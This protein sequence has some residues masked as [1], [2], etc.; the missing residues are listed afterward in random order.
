TL[1]P[2][3]SLV[4]SASE[5]AKTWQNLTG[6]TRS[7]AVVGGM[8]PEVKDYVLLAACR[9]SEYAYEYAFNGKERNGA[10]TYWLLDSLQ[11]SSLN[12]T[13]KELYSRI[14]AKIHSQFQQ[15]TPML[16]GEDNRLVLGSSYESQQY[17]VTVMQV[18]AAKDPVRLKLNAG[19][20]QGVEEGS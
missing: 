4:A 19:V 10:L 2:T 18:D 8:L 12:L 5:L 13:Y 7:A 3:E 9:P 16:L 14:N 1:R 20:A 11:N 6:G 17:A 15:Q